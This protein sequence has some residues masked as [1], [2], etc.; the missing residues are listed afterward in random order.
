MGQMQAA[1]HAAAAQGYVA[2]CL[3]L[4]TC[5]HRQ[6][7]AANVKGGRRLEAWTPHSPKD[8]QSIHQWPA[9][10]TAAPYLLMGSH[11]LPTPHT[12]MAPDLIIG[13]QLKHARRF[14]Q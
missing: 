5:W 3:S 8:S 12:W 9:G 11:P 14:K 10:A 4:I 6:S 7:S 13:L 2:L 1:L